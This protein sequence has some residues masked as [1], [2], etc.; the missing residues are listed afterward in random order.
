MNTVPGQMVPGRLSGLGDDILSAHV[1]IVDDMAIMRKMI[2][3]SLT[4]AGFTNLHEADDGDV[5][6][7]A[8]HKDMP[9]IIILDLNMPRMN[10]FDVCRQLRA[11]PKTAD[12]PILIQSATEAAE[13]RVQVFEV[14]ATDFVTKPI[15]QPELLARVCMHLENRIL[16]TSLES[17]KDRVSQELDMARSMQEDI[18]PTPE[19][20]S[21]LSLGGKFQIG[22]KYEASSEL[23]GDLWGGWKIDDQHI[24][25]FSLDVVGHGVASA[26]NTFRIHSAMMRMRSLYDKPAE[27]L[28]TLNQELAGYM[29]IGHF[30]T[31]IYGVL[32]VE[33]GTF[34]YAG[35]G[36]PGPIV[37]DDQSAEVLDSSGYPIG[38]IKSATYEDREA[39]LKP[40]QTILMYSDVMIEGKDADGN[41]LETE[42]F[43]NWVKADAAKEPEALITSL[44]DRLV[45][46]CGLPF[47]D[48]LTL[49]AV[50]RTP[51]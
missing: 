26:M 25:V 45:D 24:G 21:D 51:S 14:G 47:D 46:R 50:R 23:G 1:L 42:G 28:H 9:D 35:G 19:L 43:L 3:M 29:S 36:A 15:N 48:D 7:E 11:D 49:V 34:R 18:L 17:F 33:T 13:E 20:I 38:V 39:V 5:A 22:A 31:I 44:Y 16:I 10:G 30:A 32:N 40:G 12:I 6:I 2:A 8:I 27:F 4:K 37:F 41:L